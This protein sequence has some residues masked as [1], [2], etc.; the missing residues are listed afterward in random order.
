MDDER[1]KIDR[2]P[3]VSRL[4]LFLLDRSWAGEEF[5][6]LIDDHSHVKSSLTCRR[7]CF[8]RWCWLRHT[9]YLINTSKANINYRYCCSVSLHSDVCCYLVPTLAHDCRIL[10]LP[11]LTTY[12]F[13]DAC[14]ASP[15]IGHNEEEENQWGIERER[16]KQ[17]RKSNLPL[18]WASLITW[19]S[20]MISSKGN[21]LSKEEKD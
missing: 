20:E 18:L 8:H 17:T 6:N 4:W 10:Q 3:T 19:L 14:D 13:S 1:D 12:I 2:S 11:I 9:F 7:R 16:E 5:Q 15:I 21:A